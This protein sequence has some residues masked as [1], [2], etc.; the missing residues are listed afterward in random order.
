MNRMLESEKRLAEAQ[1]DGSLQR[2][3]MHRVEESIAVAA[4]RIKALRG[5]ASRLEG[6]QED[7]RRTVARLEEE[8][9]ALGGTLAELR[10][11]ESAAAGVLADSEGGARRMRSAAR[12][13]EDGSPDA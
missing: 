2:E 8:S 13:G 6:E 5:N 3:S 12:R 11:R 7:L 9:V 10:E 4:E 1:R